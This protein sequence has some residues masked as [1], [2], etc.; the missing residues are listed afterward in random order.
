MSP[1]SL[2]DRAWRKL[3]TISTG[4]TMLRNLS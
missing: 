4:L 3:S 2:V 1:M